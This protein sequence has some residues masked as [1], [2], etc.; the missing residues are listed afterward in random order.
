MEPRNGSKVPEVHVL[1]NCGD[2]IDG[3]DKARVAAGSGAVEEPLRAY[4]H[5]ARE[6]GD[7]ET[8]P[9]MATGSVLRT[10]RTRQ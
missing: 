1:G 9:G 4:K 8:G 2:N 7:P 6:P 3:R 10:E 5:S